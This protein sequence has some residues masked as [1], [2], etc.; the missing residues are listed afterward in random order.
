MAALSIN[1]PDNLTE[2]STI[3]A[4][5]LGISRTEF[6]KRA[7]IHEV[8]EIK[9]QEVQKGLISSLT[10]MKKDKLYQ[11]HIQEVTEEFEDCL[12]N[13]ELQWWKKKF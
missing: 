12:P 1:L 9:K 5:K 3:F 2:E 6:I 7:I 8:E 4:K 11:K 13:E 10:A